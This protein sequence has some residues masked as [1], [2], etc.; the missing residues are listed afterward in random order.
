MINLKWIKSLR[1][2]YWQETNLHKLAF[3]TARIYLQFLWTIYETLWKNSKFI[4]TITSKNLCRNDLDEA[5]FD[6]DAVYSES[7]DLA[8]GTISDKTTR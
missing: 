7:R 8:K 4:E 3:K 6:H 2:F 5:S 1:N